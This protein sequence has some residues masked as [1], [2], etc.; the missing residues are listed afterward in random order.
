[1]LV[2]SRRAREY[3][4]IYLNIEIDR[5]RDRY[6]DRYICWVSTPA[7]NKG[8]LIISTGE[9]IVS[10]YFKQIFFC[11]VCQLL[12]SISTCTVDKCTV[13]VSKIENQTNNS[14][15]GQNSRGVSDIRPFL[16]PAA[17]YSGQP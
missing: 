7:E 2:A 6:I 12:R 16:Y 11:L 10:L 15:S 13:N 14:L 8:S 5:D 17:G 3:I 4:G 9:P 1:M